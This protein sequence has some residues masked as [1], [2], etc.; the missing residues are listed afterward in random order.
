MTFVS[1]LNNFP[2]G[3]F[4]SRFMHRTNLRWFSL[5]HI[6]QNGSCH[7]F[8]PTSLPHC[9]E[10]GI[11]SLAH[12]SDHR[13]E[14]SGTSFERSDT[15]SRGTPALVFCLRMCSFPFPFLTI[16]LGKNI[17]I[18]STCLPVNSVRFIFSKRIRQSFTKNFMLITFCG[19]PFLCIIIKVLYIK[20]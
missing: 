2:L 9:L 1:L 3:G 19:L 20:L 16:F 4:S 7:D 10:T 5:E 18:G 17:G 8:C 14:I 13:T 15:A 11:L 6:N 12:K